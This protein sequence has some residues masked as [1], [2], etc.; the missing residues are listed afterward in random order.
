MCKLC[1]CLGRQTLIC[2]LEGELL[3][4]LHLIGLWIHGNWEWPI[5][6]P[7]GG[8]YEDHMKRESGNGVLKTYYKYMNSSAYTFSQTPQL[9]LIS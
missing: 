9:G 8:I 4:L 6:V 7:I 1:H 5:A 3:S 2:I